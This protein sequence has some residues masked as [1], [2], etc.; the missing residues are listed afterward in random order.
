MRFVIVGAGPAGVIAAETLRKLDDHAAITL[1]GDEHRAPYS[2]MAI[3]YFL[4][5]QIDEDG[6]LLR[7][8]P[9]HFRRLGI[10]YRSGRVAGV[11]TGTRTVRLD[12]GASEPYDRLLIATGSRPVTPPIPGLAGPGI[13][14][15]WTVQDARAIDT[16]TERAAHVVLIGAGFIGSIIL[17]ALHERGVPLT[18]VE[19]ENRMVPRMLNEPAGQMLARWCEARGVTVRTSARVA[20]VERGTQRRH[21]LAFE[22]GE[23]IEADLIVVATGVRPRVEFLEGSGITIR[24]GI[25]V[26]EHLRTSVPDVYAAGDAAEGPD[27]STGG[28]A[29]HPIQPTAADHGRIAALNMAGAPTPYH[30]SLIMNVLDTLGLVSYSF[31]QWMGV[32]GGVHA[33]RSVP[34][35][36][37]YTRLELQEDRLVGGIV[38]GHHEGIGALRGLIQSKARLGAWKARLLDDPARF[39]EAYLAQTQMAR[40]PDPVH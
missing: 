12:G 31:G 22:R 40:V 19:T 24:Q 1:I 27:H 30:G 17:N 32:A 38:V 29:V 36:F 16:E 2:R 7:K 34:D 25:V 8:E 4:S 37:R 15:C 35:R 20:S 26:D 3:P 18:V 33:E 21:R 9:D 10:T 39:V 11:D 6:M 28:H 13:H 23:P 14:P 5:R